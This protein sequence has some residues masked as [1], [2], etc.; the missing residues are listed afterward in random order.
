M[1]PNP[2]LEEQLGALRRGG[3]IGAFAAAL[4]HRADE[5]ARGRP[6]LVRELR[7]VRRL[8]VPGALAVALALGVEGVPVVPATWVLVLAWLLLCGWTWAELG[9]IRHPLSGKPGRRIGPA[10]VMTLFRG[11]AAVPVAMIA[12]YRPGP[13]LAWVVLCLVAGFT[14]LIDGSLAIRLGHESRLGRVLDPVLDA[15]FFSATGFAL[16][17]WGLLPPWMAVLVALRY[18]IP[19]VGGLALLFIRGRS[20]PVRHTPWGQ[21][22]TL[23]TAVA[24]FVSLLAT[25]VPIPAGVLLGLYAIAVLNM[26]LALGG[27]ARR[28]PRAA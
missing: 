13:T 9:L 8:G 16:A 1:A 5:N 2:F 10:N 24:L 19:V 27:I 20:L 25:R 17:R 12:L 14:D 18:F 11:W 6:D 23:A 4:W 21:R 3:G 26:A 7:V 22:S 15:C 28:A